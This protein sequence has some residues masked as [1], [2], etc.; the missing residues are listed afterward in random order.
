MSESNDM[1]NNVAYNLIVLNDIKD[2]YDW[3]EV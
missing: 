2:K 3:N 1:N